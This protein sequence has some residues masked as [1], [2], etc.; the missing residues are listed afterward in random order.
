MTALD[1]KVAELRRQHLSH[2]KGEVAA[3]QQRAASRSSPRRPSLALADA[4]AAAAATTI[5]AAAAAP[6]ES[7]LQ[8]TPPPDLTATERKLARLVAGAPAKP[9]PPRPSSARQ[10]NEDRAAG[11]ALKHPD[12]LG[13]VARK[14]LVAVCGAGGKDWTRVYRRYLRRWQRGGAPSPPRSHRAASPPWLSP[15]PGGSPDVRH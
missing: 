12:L 13:Q 15:R 10:R 1:I 7:E 5:T 8:P 14:F 2:S 3:A 11:G 9:T 6:A 4:S